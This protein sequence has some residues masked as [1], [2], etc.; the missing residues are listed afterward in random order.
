MSTFTNAGFATYNLQ[1]VFSIGGWLDAGTVQTWNIVT[2]SPG[3]VQSSNPG[4]GGAQPEAAVLHFPVAVPMANN[5]VWIRARGGSFRVSLADDPVIQTITAATDWEWYKLAVQINQQSKLRF[6]SNDPNT[7]VD[8]FIITAANETPTGVDGF[9]NTSGGSGETGTGGEGN[10]SNGGTGGS[11]TG[12]NGVCTGTATVGC[13]MIYEAETS[14]WL[15][16]GNGGAR[17]DRVNGENSGA[18]GDYIAAFMTTA[19]GDIAASAKAHLTIQPTQ[20]Q[21]WALWFRVRFDGTFQHIWADD[22]GAPAQIVNTGT[23]WSWVKSPLAHNPNASKIK[24][25]SETV[26]LQIDKVALIDTDE[27]PTG[28]SGFCQDIGGGSGGGNTGTGEEVNEE[29]DETEINDSR[30]KWLPE[31]LEC[32]VTVIPAETTNR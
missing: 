18:S 14:F 31:N 7:D 5:D 32:T 29:Y 4:T 6:F 26:G 28:V 30:F 19:A 16:Q 17:W 25:L 15:E 21:G 24:M 3:Y 27:V 20:T 9:T 10:G 13:F 8:K 2:S 12:N 1:D 22:D 23:D 11:T